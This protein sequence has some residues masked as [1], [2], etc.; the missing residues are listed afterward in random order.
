M[1]L[2]TFKEFTKTETLPDGF[3][4]FLSRLCGIRAGQLE[5]PVALPNLRT[6]ER[7]W[8]HVICIA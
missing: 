3:F 4:P 1:N 7:K 5:E 2:E 6:V 8:V